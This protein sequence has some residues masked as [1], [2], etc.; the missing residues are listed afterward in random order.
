MASAHDRVWEHAADLNYEPATPLKLVWESDQFQY[1]THRRLFA[2]ES[3][4]KTG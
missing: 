4:A 2:H 3:H 1:R